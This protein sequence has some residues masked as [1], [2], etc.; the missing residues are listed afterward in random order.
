VNLLERTRLIAHLLRWRLTWSRRDIDYCPKHKPHKDPGRNLSDK[1]VSA[2]EAA[3]L[4]PDGATVLSCGLASHARCSIFY[5]ALRELF[6]QTGHPSALTW[7]SVGAQGGRGKIP[8]TVEE[9]GIP[10]LLQCYISGHLETAKSLLR[11][12]DEGELELQTLPQGEMTWLIEAQGRGEY[13]VTSD[14]G[15]GTFLDPRVGRGSR[16]TP[17][18]QENL[19]ELV[20]GDALGFSLPRI[21]VAVANLPYADVDGNI[22]FQDSA[23]LTESI[24]AVRAA[25]HNGGKALITVC[26]I[27]DEDHDAVGLPAESIDAIVVNPYNEQTGGVRQRNPWKLFT[28]GGDGDDRKAEARLKFINEI[29]H[30]TPSRGPVENALARLGARVFTQAV[31]PPTVVNI[32]VGFPEEA[33]RLLSESDL[34]DDITF[35]TETGVYG[36]LPAPGVFF[37]AAVNPQRLETSAWMFHHYIEHL[38]ATMLGFLEVDS[39]GNVNVSKRGPR[40]LDYVG[41][42]GFPSI[43]NSAKTIV[44]IGT[45]MANAN[46]R[47]DSGRLELIKPGK[48]KFVERVDEASFNGR[49]ALARGKRV[50][51]V[52]NVGVFTLTDAGLTLIEVM[53]GIDI[54]RDILDVSRAKIMIPTDREIRAVPESVVTGNGFELSWISEVSLCSDDCMTRRSL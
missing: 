29:L 53:P 22:Y 39:T 15:I 9:L 26:D 10:G 3:G 14:T 31:S 33:A 50:F 38:D 30:I 25:R 2:R 23:S 28:P 19:I 35:T 49:V 12:A 18:T 46:W 36:G 16:V 7:L 34:H 52:T 44:L 21:D 1:F 4:I 17:K 54:E 24:E 45:W 40:M 11:L 51:Y 42:G 20:N 47:V 8:G 5:W 37:G 13:T 48:P 27:I 41:P 32:G 43:V 6:E